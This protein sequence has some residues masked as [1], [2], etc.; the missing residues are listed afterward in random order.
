MGSPSAAASPV[1]PSSAANA[2]GT[3]NAA[4][5]AHLRRCGMGMPPHR[6]RCAMLAAFC[7][8]SALAALLGLTGEAAAEGDPIALGVAYVE[9]LQSLDQHE[10]AGL[11]LFIGVLF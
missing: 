9:A 1:R 3:Q 10:L 7:V 2:L 5:I 4:S 8:P 11:A 6:R